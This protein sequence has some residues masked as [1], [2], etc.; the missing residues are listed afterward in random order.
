[1]TTQEL[2]DMDMT[3]QKN[4]E[5]IYKMLYKLKPMQKLVANPQAIKMEHLEKV[6]QGLCS[7]Y[8]YGVQTIYPYFEEQKF[9]FYCAS[10][11]KKEDTTLWK[12]NVYGRTMHEVFAKLIIKVYSEIKKE[13]KHE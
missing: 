12:G 2:I 4:R 6:L 10:V 11:T 9:V 8:N 3:E 13:K 1:M 7:R 5:I